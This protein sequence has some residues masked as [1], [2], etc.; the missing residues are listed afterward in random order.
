MKTYQ[1]TI[2][3]PDGS[4]GKAYG[5]FSSSCAAV[6]QVMDDFPNAKRISAR[7]MP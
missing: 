5:I 4:Q 7:R 2:T 6:I 3:M 1:L